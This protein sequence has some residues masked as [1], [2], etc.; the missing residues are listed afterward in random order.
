MNTN[1]EIKNYS[2]LIAEDI[3]NLI[4][5]QSK[6]KENVLRNLLNS[7]PQ[8]WGLGRIF[9]KKYGDNEPRF[10]YCAGQDYPAEIKLIRS[11]LAR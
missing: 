2:E 4:G 11:Y 7:T 9:L 6:T 10:S 3:S 8:H 1:T 5:G